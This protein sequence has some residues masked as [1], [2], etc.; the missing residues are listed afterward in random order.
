LATKPP[1]KPAHVVYA[2]ERAKGTKQADAYRKAFPK[3]RGNDMTL[4]KESKRLEQRADVRLMIREITEKANAKAAEEAVET[5][6]LSKELVLQE[7]WENS[8]IGKAAVP[9]LDRKGEPTGEY[10]A[11]LNASNAALIAI[12]KELGMFKDGAPKEDPLD[13]LTD[14]QVRALKA[15][16]DEID[17]SESAGTA[18]PSAKRKSRTTH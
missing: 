7:L 14:E 17:A 13:S 6:S 18:R 2:T 3:A 8:Q 5:V 16:L 4:V 15:A 10:T 12:G 11:N 9:V 1:M